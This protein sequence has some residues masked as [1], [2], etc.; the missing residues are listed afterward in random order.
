MDMRLLVAGSREYPEGLR[1][2]CVSVLNLVWA[3][4]ERGKVLGDTFHVVSGHSVDKYDEP[5][6]PDWWAECWAKQ[7]AYLGVTGTF[8]SIKDIGGWGAYPGKSAGYHRNL[9]LAEQN[10]TH[11]LFFWD[12]Q[13][14]GT[15][16]MLK[17]IN[18]IRPR[19]RRKT[20]TPDMFIPTAFEWD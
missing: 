19:I 16:G 2:Q 10:L 1:H 15:Y 13:S 7:Y 8:I 4:W 3:E 18:K 9:K 5:I 12:G 14:R 20:I 11:A 6:G 17:I